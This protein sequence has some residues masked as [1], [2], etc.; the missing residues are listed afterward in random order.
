MP[1]SLGARPRYGVGRGELVALRVACAAAGGVALALLGPLVPEADAKVFHSQEEALELAFPGADRIES[2]TY[3]LSA[4]Q[5][6]AIEKLSR[7]GL[8]S[9]LI[10]LFSAWRGDELMGRALIDV[11]TVR[12]MPEAFMIVLSPQ[13]RVESLRVLAFYE[14][15]EYMPTQRWYEQF[16]GSDGRSLEAG[17]RL[18]RDVYGV[19]GATLSARAVTQSVRRAIAFHRVLVMNAQTPASSGAAA[20]ERAALDEPASS[21]WLR[22]RPWC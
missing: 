21:L 9:E 11:H 15:T 10:T 17:L 5:K 20:T 8:E 13:G 2:Q 7:S 6:Q 16:R 12:T 14:P 1:R 19:A 18:G 22:R 3:I 4:A